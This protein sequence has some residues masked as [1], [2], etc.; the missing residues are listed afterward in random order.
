[1]SLLIRQQPRLLWRLCQSRAFSTSYRLWAEQP[2][3]DTPKPIADAATSKSVTPA[4]KFVPPSPLADAP[5]S[6]G[7]RLDSFTPTPLSR[8][9]GLAYPPE[10]GQN[11]G[12]D[13]RT[14][15]QRRDDFVDYDK[16]LERRQNLYNKISRPYFRDWGNM[17][18]HK[19]KTFIA[20]PRLFRGE[21]SLFFPNLYGRTL[22]KTDTTPRDTTPVLR[23]RVSVVS[24]FSSL[25]AENQCK[26]FVS[27]ESNPAVEQAIAESG[28]RAQHVRVNI[29]EDALK[30]FL[31]KLWM[32]R[33][34]RQ[35]GGEENYER[36][37]LVRKGV[38]DEIREAIGL[39][40]SKVGYVYLLDADCRI[41]WAGSGPSEDHEREGL[42]KGLQRLLLEDA[43]A[44]K[45]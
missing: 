37:F 14:L 13:F 25:W 21:L 3:K 27:P 12:I 16:H 7:K 24:V 5:R 4:P 40:N 1:M 19:G 29:E 31:V 38:S 30:A 32:G 33:L 6:Y 35:V 44:K 9:I 17:Q 42:V 28:G 43:N 20:P 34:R 23:G 41:R 22:L 10:A 36:Y 11:T 45:Q 2:A 26:T 15:K 39:L 8:P 18:F